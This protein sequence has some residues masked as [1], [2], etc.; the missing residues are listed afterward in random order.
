MFLKK[1]LIVVLYFTHNVNNAKMS[2][3]T[4]KIVENCGQLCGLCVKDT[5]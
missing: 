1:T 2:L 3:K 5:P 4:I